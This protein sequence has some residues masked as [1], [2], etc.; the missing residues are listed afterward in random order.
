MKAKENK[1]NKKTFNLVV[2]IT[3]G[4]AAIASAVVTYAQPVFA[5]QIVAAIGIVSTAVSEVC[6]LFVKAE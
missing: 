1:M 4:C 3:G 6:S 2:G 5:V